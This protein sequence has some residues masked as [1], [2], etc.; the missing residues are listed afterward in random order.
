MF[1]KIKDPECYCHTNVSPQF[2]EE[3]LGTHEDTSAFIHIIIIVFSN[4]T[5]VCFTA[6]TGYNL[7]FE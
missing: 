1:T 5:L 4:S 7:Q 3:A 2:I 6:V